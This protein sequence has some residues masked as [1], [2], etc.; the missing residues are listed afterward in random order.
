MLNIDDFK[1]FAKSGTLAEVETR[2]IGRLTSTVVVITVSEL[3]VDISSFTFRLRFT[4][5]FISHYE[6]LISRS[7]ES[8]L[9]LGW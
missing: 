1:G 5:L 2:L 7:V 8:F 9:W 4:A 3:F 6:P